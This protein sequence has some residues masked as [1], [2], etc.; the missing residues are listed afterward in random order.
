MHTGL[1]VFLVL[2]GA[3]G[4]GESRNL[5]PVHGRVSF[6]GGKPPASGLLAFVPND[7]PARRVDTG[8]D[9]RPGRAIFDADG[10]YKAAT[11]RDADGLRPGTYDVRVICETLPPGGDP[12]TAAAIS[13]VPASFNAPPL[14]V[15]KD[16][17]SAVEYNIDVPAPRK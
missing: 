9:P 17:R 16:A 1:L 2:V 14:E 3:V 10:K 4:C 8:H 5:V 15:P 6:G 12:E 11:F 7:M 13:Y